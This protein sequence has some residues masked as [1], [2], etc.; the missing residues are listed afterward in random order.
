MIGKPTRRSSLHKRRNTDWKWNKNKKNHVRKEERT[1]PVGSLRVG[2]NE[3][4]RSQSGYYLELENE[5]CISMKKKYKKG[6]KKNKQKKQGG[7]SLA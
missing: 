7:F 6:A 3:G 4:S 1:A 5:W 2:V